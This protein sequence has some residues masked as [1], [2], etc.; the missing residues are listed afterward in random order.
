MLQPTSIRILIV[1]DHPAIRTGLTELLGSQPDMCVV[2][3]ACDGLEA[4]A[5]LPALQPD[6]TLL[7][8]RLPRL[9]GMDVL[10]RIR[11]QFPGSRVIAMS[12]F[13][14]KQAQTLEAGANAFLLKELFGEEL[15]ALVRAVCASAATP[16]QS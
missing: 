14:D 5:L 3:T 7:D 9:S 15:L 8:M 13:Q 1:D 4:L 6:V 11:H 2:G 16:N 12:S 10:R